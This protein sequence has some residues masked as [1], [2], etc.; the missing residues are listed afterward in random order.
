MKNKYS[1]F[2][3]NKIHKVMRSLKR[4]NEEG[5]TVRHSRLRKFGKRGRTLA[6]L[7]QIAA[8]WYLSFA[9]VSY[10][11][12][13]T[14]A[15][16]NDVETYSFGIKAEWEDKEPEYPPSDNDWG[17]SSLKEVS[18]G[19]SCSPENGIFASFKNTGESVDHE[20]TRYEIYWSETEDNVKNGEI[21]KKGTFPIPDKGEVYEIHYQPE[22]NGFYKFKAYHEVGHANGN[23]GDDKGP[24]SGTIH[25]TDCVDQ[26]DGEGDTIPQPTDEV[27]PAEIISLNGTPTS[28]S[29]TLSWNNPADLDFKHVNVY[30]DGNL[31]E[32][33]ITSEIYEDTNLEP[34]KI[35]SYKITTIDETENESAGITIEVTTIAIDN[36]PPNE[37]L[38]Q[39]VSRSGKSSNLNLSWKNPTEDFS[40]VRIYIVG[41]EKPIKDNIT[42][43]EIKNLD[44]GTQNPV[45]LKITTV[46]KMGNESVGITIGPFIIE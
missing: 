37:V 7:A 27:A 13:D 4:T 34:N 11:T 29:I 33:N 24:W 16:F 26:E 1:N 28:D 36:I 25:V 5:G 2:V 3:L 41:Q 12:T 17:N 21:V 32:S 31:I 40:Y 35:Y 18:Q 6:L 9:M 44:V 30:R 46:D 42:N 14:G 45:T 38:I 19:G 22:K 15:Y 23:N 20:L 10:L 43:E 8:I 39:K